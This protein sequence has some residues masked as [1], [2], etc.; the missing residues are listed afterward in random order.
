MT[1]FGA[2]L[3]IRCSRSLKVDEC[4]QN[5]SLTRGSNKL[6]EFYHSNGLF[7]AATTSLQDDEL[8]LMGAC[9]TTHTLTFDLSISSRNGVV[10]DTVLL[11]G[12][13]EITLTPGIQTCFAYTSIVKNGSEWVTVRR[14]RVLTQE[15]QVTEE[16]ESIFSS[17]DTEALAVVSF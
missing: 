3:R 12:I 2:M 14:L 6:A 13:H 1:A 9:D 16:T 10:E 8:Y 4:I 7:G 15:L 11:D 5:F 17:L